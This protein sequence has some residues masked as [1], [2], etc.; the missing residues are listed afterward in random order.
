MIV[1]AIDGRFLGSPSKNNGHGSGCR[2]C[3]NRY[4]PNSLY[5]CVRPR[6]CVGPPRSLFR[7]P[8]WRSP[9]QAP[10]LS[11][12]DTESAGPTQRAPRSDA[13]LRHARARPGPD[14]QSA[15]APTQSARP[16]TQTGPR[17][18][19]EPDIKRCRA[20]T[21]SVARGPAT[22]SRSLFRAP[23]LSSASHPSGPR[24]PRIWSCRPPNESQPCHPVRNPSSEP[25]AT[26]P[27][28][29]PSSDPRATHPARAAF[30][31]ERT[32]NLTVWGITEILQCSPLGVL[33]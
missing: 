31:Q 20:L 23:P 15:R 25:R 1:R 5:I 17:R 26:H 2:Q 7:G 32:P 33:Y 6:V 21:L 12:S 18:A 3:P 10:A 19:S 16:D 14:I 22:L 28:R 9:C 30:F 13:E 8:A 27:V 24:A 29:A 11:E 4:N